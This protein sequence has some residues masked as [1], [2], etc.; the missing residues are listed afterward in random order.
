MYDF[1]FISF[2]P[3]R[4]LSWIVITEKKYYKITKK[5]AGTLV[6]KWWGGILGQIS[7]RE[8][9]SISLLTNL[10]HSKKTF[11]KKT[12]RILNYVKD[13]GKN[14]KK[15]ILHPIEL[16]FSL[17]LNKTFLLYFA[18]FNVF[19]IIFIWFKYYL[20]Y[21]YYKKQIWSIKWKDLLNKH[22]FDTIA[23]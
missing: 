14:D 7:L 22:V 9:F 17:I 4:M 19:L 13:S 8:I 3:I 23:N 21:Y 1:I 11:E 6:L 16:I 10:K 15:N 12:I 20:C 5:D 2:F 18:V